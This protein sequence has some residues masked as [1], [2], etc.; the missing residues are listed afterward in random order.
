[1]PPDSCRRG[2]ESSHTVIQDDHGPPEGSHPFQKMSWL[3]RQLLPVTSAFHGRSHRAAPPYPE[4]RKSL[5]LWSVGPTRAV[6][7]GPH[8]RRPRQGPQPSSPSKSY[9]MSYQG[10]DQWSQTGMEHPSD[11]GRTFQKNGTPARREHFPVSLRP[12]HCGFT[13]TQCSSRTAGQR[14][15]LKRRDFR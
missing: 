7:S 6:A 4:W 1:M 14:A 3:S 13:S 5:Q 9:S 10:R 2:A 11:M 8:R 12:T 15:F